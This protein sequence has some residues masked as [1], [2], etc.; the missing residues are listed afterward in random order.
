MK[1][2]P[3]GLCLTVRQGHGFYIGESLVFIKD[4]K[5]G[6]SGPIRLKVV[7]PRSIKV[8]YDPNQPQYE[9]RD[10]EDQE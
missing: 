3:G 5:G 9:D 2:F 8:S 10:Q 7:S 6:K 1:D 4:V